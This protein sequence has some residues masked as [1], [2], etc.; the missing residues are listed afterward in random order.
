MFEWKIFK[1]L[2]QPPDILKLYF[3]KQENDNTRVVQLLQNFIFKNALQISLIVIQKL[4]HIIRGITNKS[5]ARQEFGESA[6]KQI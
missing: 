2:S 1:S 3:Q 4:L 6:K 5:L